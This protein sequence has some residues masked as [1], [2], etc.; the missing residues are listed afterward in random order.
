[1][2]KGS[3]VQKYVFLKS[4]FFTFLFSFF[5]ASYSLCQRFPYNKA[6]LNFTSVMF[7]YEAYLDADEYQIIIKENKSKNTL[8]VKRKSL[9]FLCND[10]LQFG[11]TYQWQYIAF[12][13]SKK[14][15]TSTFYE[16]KILKSFLVDSSLHQFK[17]TKNLFPK[18]NTDIVLLD[19]L[20]VAINRRGQ[21]I[22]YMPTDSLLYNVNDPSRRSLR[23]THDG[24]FTYLDSKNC[25]ERDLYGKL[26]WE[27][28]NNGAVSG[29]ATEYYHH[30]FRKLKNNTYLACGY[31]YIKETH[32]FD[33]NK[34]WRVRYNTLIQYDSTGNILWSWN[35]KDH[36][37][38]GLVLEQGDATIE[39]FPGTHLNGFDYNEQQNTLL[40]SFRNTARVIKIN[41]Q[42]KEVMYVLGKNPMT[43]NESYDLGLY[44]QHGPAWMGQDSIVIYNN[45]AR[46][47]VDSN[48]TIINPKVLIFKEP[49]N[50]NELG[51][52]WEYDCKT[53]LFPGGQK[54]KE[55]YALPLKN[56]NIL[57]DQGSTHRIFEIDLKKNIQW[58]MLCNR[59]D[60]IKKNW[61]PLINY[62]AY[63]ATSLY[64][65]YFTIQQGQV[66]KKNNKIT[67]EFFINND[68]TD[69]QLMFIDA[70]ADNNSIVPQYLDKFVSAQ[71]RST[72]TLTIDA[73]HFSK[74][75]QKIYIKVFPVG[76]IKKARILSFSIN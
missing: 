40:L 1:M 73:T 34:T 55:G 54:G 9:A 5:F 20:G 18:T 56:G 49:H 61:E 11:K 57:I 32:F 44:G 71:K 38:P 17:I 26:L 21:P 30:D 68:G 42:T 76:N 64:P 46:T 15:F 33:A 7:E 69:D 27:A 45:N 72:V 4:L 48:M 47:V 19:Y 2:R 22:W 3:D 31:K 43:K 35:E 52:V 37:A 36:V 6:E 29:D 51:N 53:P 63:G 62:R 14:I 25:Y 12:K 8:Q 70:Y 75:K 13:K 28:P 23:L 39:D 74:E 10:F 60:T 66:I 41:M 24:N 59:F 16:F 58:E 65:V 50:K 67:I